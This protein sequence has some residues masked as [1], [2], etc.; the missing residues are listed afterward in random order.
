MPVQ[1]VTHEPASG[2]VT[3][4]TGHQLDAEAVRF[5][6]LAAKAGLPPLGSGT[7]QEA[8]AAREARK[9]AA[10]PA[11]VK[12]VENMECAG[13]PCRFYSSKEAGAEPEGLLMFYHVGWAMEFGMEIFWIG[14]WWTGGSDGCWN[15]SQPCEFLRI[16]SPARQPGIP[17]SPIFR[18]FQ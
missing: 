3:Y 13:V 14:I 9:P 11:P 16:V 17:R 4:S 10:P 5:L 18:C 12:R 1:P 2:Y 6:E 7:V 15:R 8:R